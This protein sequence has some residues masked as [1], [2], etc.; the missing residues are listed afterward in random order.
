MATKY[1]TNAGETITG[2]SGADTIFA[3]GGDDRLA[4]LAGADKLYG[5]GGN[6]VLD[7]GLGNDLLDGGAGIDVA[8]YVSSATAIRA[9]GNGDDGGTPGIW[10]VTTASGE[11]DTLVSVE[12]VVGSPLGDYIKG[13]DRTAD[14]IRGGAGDDQLVGG[15]YSW[16]SDTIYG[17]PGNDYVA[18]GEEIVSLGGTHDDAGDSFF[19]GAGDDRLFGLDGEDRLDGG[20][21]DDLLEGGPDRDVLVGGAGRDTFVYF[22]EDTGIGS[23]TTLG[24]FGPDLVADFRKGSDEIFFRSVEGD[25]DDPA[26]PRLRGF[27]DLDSN[28]NGTL[29]DGDRWVE[30]ERVTFGG[31]A[32]A[33]TVIDVSDYTYVQGEQSLTVFGVTGLTAAD[34]ADREFP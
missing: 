22:N 23:G 32:K 29:D 7:G 27:D 5:E 26:T 8:T 19:G 1:G 31:Q 13:G 17:G 4:G 34:F 10:S 18:G 16:A 12:R 14:L 30:V 2:T 9:S 21:G 6:D 15:T 24:S 3:R 25:P 33:S 11:R 28:G 20:D